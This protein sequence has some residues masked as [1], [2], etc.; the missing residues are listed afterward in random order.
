M[1]SVNTSV[2]LDRVTVLY[3]DLEKWKGGCMSIIYIMYCNYTI[4]FYLPKLYR[5]KVRN[6]D[7][8]TKVRTAK[9]MQNPYSF[10]VCLCS[11]Y[12]SSE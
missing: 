4:S 9:T 8:L 11:T 1:L 5:V 7:G 2:F 3:P 12:L 10:T 6:N